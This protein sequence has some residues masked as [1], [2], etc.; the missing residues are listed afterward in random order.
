MFSFYTIVSIFVNV[1]IR[2]LIFGLVAK[3]LRAT[4]L[5]KGKQQLD[6]V[7][8]NQKA[9]SW[10][11]PGIV[12]SSPGGSPAAVAA[13]CDQANRR[14]LRI[15][16]SFQPAIKGSKMASFQCEEQANRHQ[17]TWIQFGLT[18]LGY[19]FHLV[20]DK[21]KNLDDNVFGGHK[22][23]SFQEQVGFSLEHDLCGLLN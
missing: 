14:N 2:S 9:K 11:R 15:I 10:D 21:T 16:V 17:L 5:P 19:L 23:S 20:I 8:V 12:H 6:G 22:A 13:V 7:A 18:M 1:F 4:P 3:L